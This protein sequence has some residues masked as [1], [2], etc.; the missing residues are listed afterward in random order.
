MIAGRLEKLLP[1]GFVEG[2]ACDAD[3]PTAAL[4]IEVREAG[5]ETVASGFA[6]LFRD[7][8]A[9][10]GVGLGWCAFR[11][12]L[13][14]PVETFRDAR[15]TLHA[16]ASAGEIDSAQGLPL[17]PVE[18]AVTEPDPFSA[19]TIQAL[20]G[21]E[22]LFDAYRKGLGARAFARVAYLYVLNRRAD[23]ESLALN[24]ALLEK[25]AITP[26]GLIA[27]LGESQEA[28][29]EPRRFASPKAPEFP[30]VGEASV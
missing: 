29:S 16:I 1:E 21:A 19:A 4:E 20:R 9:D 22:T 30:F 17:D 10:I 8:L 25:G 5:G 27:L 7:D 13:A 12:R 24:L 11:L 14:R 18:A 6:N 23:P 26:F 15:L 28:L 3:L 2:W